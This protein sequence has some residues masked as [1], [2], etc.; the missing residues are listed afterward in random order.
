MWNILLIII[1]CVCWSAFASLFCASGIKEQVK[2]QVIYNLQ[3]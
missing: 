3:E 2:L 1:V